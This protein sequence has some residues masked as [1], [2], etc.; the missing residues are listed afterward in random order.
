VQAFR[1]GTLAWGVQFHPEAP[2]SRVREWDGEKLAAQGFDHGTLVARAD[3]DDAVNAE[4][5]RM[6]AGAF[7][8]V[9]REGRR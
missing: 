6:L 4:Q 5:A 9:V 3:A 1:V 2:A 7:A 8:K